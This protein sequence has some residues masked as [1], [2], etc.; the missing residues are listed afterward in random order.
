MTAIITSIKVNPR[1]LV[2]VLVLVLVLVL[3]MSMD[4]S[5][6]IVFQ[7]KSKTPKMSRRVEL[8]TV[9]TVWSRWYARLVVW[10]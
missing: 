6:S 4:A 7:E 3:K 8:L 9:R 2:W 1:L 5:V 10:S